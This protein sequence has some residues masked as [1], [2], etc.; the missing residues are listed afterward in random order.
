MK[1]IIFFLLLGSLVGCTCLSQI[2]TQYYFLNDSCDFYLPD[3]S[4]AVQVRDNC[5]VATFYQVP[6]SGEIL[7]AGGEYRVTLYA[8]DQQGN[9]SSMSFDIV[10]IDNLPPEFIY[11]DSTVLIPSGHYQNDIR[12]WHFWTLVKDSSDFDLYYTTDRN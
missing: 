1:R 4:Q 3:Y 11:L 6:D 12:T 9:Q 5:S 8:E 2:P 10:L 7:S